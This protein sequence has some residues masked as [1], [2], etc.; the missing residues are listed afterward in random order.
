VWNL[1]RAASEHKSKLFQKMR[2][3]TVIRKKGMEA[4]LT[5]ACF[6]SIFPFVGICS[7]LSSP[8]DGGGF[9]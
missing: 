9:S 8:E 2:L 1:L 6:L 3:W 7:F 4:L 5:Q